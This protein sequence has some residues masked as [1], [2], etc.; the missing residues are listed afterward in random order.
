V[1]FVGYWVWGNLVPPDLM[2]TLAGS[3]IQPG[4]G[5]AVN[6][7]LDYYGIDGDLQ[8]AGPVPGAVLNFLR[9]E[10]TALA[11]WLSIAILLALAAAALAGGQAL[12]TRRTR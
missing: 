11:G 2:P 5:Y 4:G 3:V 12:R 1:L 9:P 10:P 8:L 6:A 7:L